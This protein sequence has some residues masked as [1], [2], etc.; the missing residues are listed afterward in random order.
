MADLRAMGETNA[1]IERRGWPSRRKTFLRAAELYQERHGGPDGRIPA[2][3]QILPLTAWAPHE[4]QQQPLRPGSA[5]S[6]LAEALDGEEVSAGEK[7][8]RE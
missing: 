7:A 8:G 3:F 6:R 4:S 5:K 1:V 2:T